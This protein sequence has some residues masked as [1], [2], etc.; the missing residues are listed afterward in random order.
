MQRL[1]FT[2]VGDGSSDRALIPILTWLLREYWEDVP[3]QAEFSDLRW[4][5]DPPKGLSQRIDKSIELYPCDLLFVHRDAEGES[6]EKRRE[7]IRESLEWSERGKTLPVICVIPVRMQEAWLLIDESA[8]KMAAGNPSNHQAL[9]MPDV[10]RLENL[11]DPKR[12]LHDL[13]RQASGLQGRRRLKR[14]DRDLGKCVQRVT[15]QIDDFHPLR[16]LAAFRM[17]EDRVAA[18]RRHL[19]QINPTLSTETD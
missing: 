3:I 2:L 6:V 10:R 11:P 8:L 12:I 1:R 13:L 15:Q 7:E 17:L 4:L 18:H 14:F 19:Q 16:K 5:P 9:P